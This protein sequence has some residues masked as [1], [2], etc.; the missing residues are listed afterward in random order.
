MNG[1]DG[2]LLQVRLGGKKKVSFDIT[3]E[4]ETFFGDRDVIR[5]NTGKSPVDE[6]PSSF[7]Y[8]LEFGPLR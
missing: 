5:R 6:I 1:E 2:T 3:T 4:K 7:D 8:S